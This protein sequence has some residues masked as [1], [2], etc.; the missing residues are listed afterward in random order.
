[1]STC[2][3]AG[4]AITSGRRSAERGVG[5]EAFQEL[6]RWLGSESSQR[7]GLLRVERE[8]QWRGQEVL[9]LLLQEHIEG[10][11]TGDVGVALRVEVTNDGA[12]SYTHK[13]LHSRSLITVFG[14]VSITRTG[15]GRPGQRWIHPLD[16]ELQLPARVY[17][18]EVQRRVVKAAVLGPFDE[19]IALL[20]DLNGIEVPKRSAEQIVL[21][22]STDFEAF[23][24]QRRGAKGEPDGAILVAAIDCKGIPMVKAGPAEAAVRLGKGKKRQ[25]KRMSTV[26]T[27]FFHQ[28][29]P[30]TPEDVVQSLFAAPKPASESRRGP[31]RN[32][33]QNK[34]VWASLLADKTA[35]ITGVREEML[36]RDPDHQLPWVIVTDG[37]RALQQRVC[38]LLT[39]VPLVLDLFHVL[40]KLWKAA[41]ALHPEG[42][43]EAQSFVRDRTLRIL[44]GQVGQV[45]KGLRQM[46]TKHRLRGAKHKALS[47]AANYLYRN[48]G[49]MQ[50]DVYLQRGWPIASGAVEGACKNLVKD[51]MERSG[52]R[53]TPPMAEAMLRLRATHLSED[54]EEYWDF[55]VRQDQQ[56]LYPN[57]W[58]VV[59]E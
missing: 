15:Y 57:L 16:A 48:R 22:A 37:E 47:G 27:V 3:L 1:M 9:R 51:R 38:A 26:A 8:T 31:A 36:R 20:A 13:R 55:H 18:Y 30:R 19:A 35:F 24:D 46:V 29:R 52:M 33:P 17:S 59:E 44:R 49:R 39:D 45:V 14:E 41:H 5:R 4:P 56:R 23:Y 21:D 53:W 58:T 40:E 54:F 25:K 12:L 7:L 34:R 32:R 11:G 42:S 2:T 43:P 10:R 6:E 28:P 50:Y